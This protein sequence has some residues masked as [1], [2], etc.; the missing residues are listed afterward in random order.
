MCNHVEYQVYCIQLCKVFATEGLNPPDSVI[1]QDDW[2][3]EHGWFFNTF[4]YFLLAQIR[5][6]HRSPGSH[7]KHT[8]DLLCFCMIPEA[9]PDLSLLNSLCVKHYEINSFLGST[10]LGSL[11]SKNCLF[12]S[13]TNKASFFGYSKNVHLTHWWAWILFLLYFSL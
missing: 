2:L 12:V 3:V 7:F 5:T 13:D 4:F 8:W 6:V 10:L 11:S 1:I 9:I